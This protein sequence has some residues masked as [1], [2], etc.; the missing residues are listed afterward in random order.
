MPPKRR[1]RTS[2]REQLQ[3]RGAKGQFYRAQEAA[4]VKEG[5]VWADRGSSSGPTRP[6]L[7]D[8]AEQILRAITVTDICLAIFLVRAINT[9]FVGRF[10]IL[11]LQEDLLQDLTREYDSSS[12]VI[13]L[14]L[15]GLVR[16]L[17]V[18]YVFFSSLVVSLI[19]S[20]FSLTH[21]G[22]QSKW[23]KIKAWVFVIV[24]ALQ[25]CFPLLKLYIFLRTGQLADDHVTD[26]KNK[27]M[28]SVSRAV[29]VTCLRVVMGLLNR[30][31]PMI[32]AAEL[33]R[34][35]WGLLGAASDKGVPQRLAC[36]P[37]E[38]HR[39]LLQESRSVGIL[40]WQFSMASSLCLFLCLGFLASLAVVGGYS[41][42]YSSYT[43]LHQPSMAIVVILGL[44]VQFAN[45]VTWL[46]VVR[47]SYYDVSFSTTDTSCTVS[48][49]VLG[50]AW[51]NGMS[52]YFSST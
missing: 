17:I 2:T 9:F 12:S 16:T 11:Q 18:H 23:D 46:L 47:A 4:G 28:V 26:V 44:T 7:I 37:C 30:A 40:M 25:L 15:T 24:C 6:A 10:R 39:R 32:G 36:L 5:T 34:V 51:G 22:I 21:R 35:Y 27:S 45:G 41:D 19:W 42:L 52:R 8:W 38:A 14:L 13:N 33:I 29:V 20:S 43:Q 49:N 31:A 3:P 50:G 1:K 48:M